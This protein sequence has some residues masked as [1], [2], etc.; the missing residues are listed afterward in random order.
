M[1]WVPPPDMT[2]VPPPCGTSSAARV[3]RGSEFDVWPGLSV[4]DPERNPSEHITVTVVIYN[5]VANGVP[6]EEDVMAAID[7]LE[8]LYEKCQVKGR[9]EE[10]TFDFM[11]KELKAEDIVDIETKLLQ[12]PSTLSALPLEFV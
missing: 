11:K 9:L 5:T 1:Q 2:F 4:Q 3:S 10:A 7:D 6:S 12:Q 8:S